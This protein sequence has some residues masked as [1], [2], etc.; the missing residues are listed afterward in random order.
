MEGLVLAVIASAVD[1]EFF[2]VDLSGDRGRKF[3]FE[4]SLRALDEHGA[5]GVN[6]HFDLGR[7]G[8]GFFT[9]A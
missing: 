3:P 8:D 7:D 1:G 6:G 4:F 5:V 9:D 2:P